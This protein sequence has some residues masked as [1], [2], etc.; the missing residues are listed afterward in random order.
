MLIACIHK[1]PLIILT[2]N[3]QNHQKPQNFKFQKFYENL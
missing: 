2:Q 1:N 3:T